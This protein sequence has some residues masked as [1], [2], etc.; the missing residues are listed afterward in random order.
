MNWYETNF[1][2]HDV[3]VNDRRLGDT[4]I[5]KFLYVYKMRHGDDG[6]WTL[7]VTVEDG[8]V[9]VN[10]FGTMISGN[11]IVMDEGDHTELGDYESEEIGYSVGEYDKRVNSL[12]EYSKKFINTIEIL[13]TVEIL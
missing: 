10:H 8:G 5:P 13:P 7:P 6:D 3:V 4:I 1:R 2:S 11:P 12:E 9:M